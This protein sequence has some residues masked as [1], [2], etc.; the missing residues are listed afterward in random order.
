MSVG[1]GKDALSDR[2]D[3]YPT[4]KCLPFKVSNKRVVVVDKFVR[5]FHDVIVTVEPLDVILRLFD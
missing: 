5:G 2:Q 1:G 4:G 3:A